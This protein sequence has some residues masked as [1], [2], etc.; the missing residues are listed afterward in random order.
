VPYEKGPM[1]PD[2]ELHQADKRKKNKVHCSSGRLTSSRCYEPLHSVK[3]YSVC[4]PKMSA[5][6]QFRAE[7]GR[8]QE[9][10]IAFKRCRRE[11]AGAVSPHDQWFLHVKLVA[12]GVE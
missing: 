2:P 9:V 11:V 7:I 4:H 3:V 12:D 1:S 5:D 10:A 8:N 6:I